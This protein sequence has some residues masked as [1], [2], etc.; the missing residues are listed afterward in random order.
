M[1]EAVPIAPPSTPPS[2]PSHRRSALMELKQTVKT[3]K[4][5]HNLLVDIL[6]P[7]TEINAH[8]RRTADLR[9]ERPRASAA[10]S[11]MSPAGVAPVGLGDTFP[12]PQEQSPVPCEPAS[13]HAAV[14]VPTCSSTGR[15]VRWSPAR[16]AVRFVQA[17]EQASRPRRRRSSLTELTEAGKTLKMIHNLLVD[18]LL[19]VE[20]INSRVRR[21][22]DLRAEHPRGDRD[23]HNRSYN[24]SRSR[25][26]R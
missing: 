16:E 13:S 18:I 5:I 15:E 23:D 14:A 25:R 17:T 11:S 3:L 6:L 9:A 2:R 10:V 24:R 21:A 12:S 4:M 8:V 20:Q 26:R 19:P 22:A 1:E 7:V